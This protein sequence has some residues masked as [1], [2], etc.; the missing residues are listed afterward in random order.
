MILNF[1]YLAADAVTTLPDSVG[2]GTASGVCGVLVTA[3][4]WLSKIYLNSIELARSEYKTSHQELVMLT[5]ECI[6]AIR[7]FQATMM[8]LI[9]KLDLKDNK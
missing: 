8:E 7:E 4:I 3:I 2:L 9:N 5:R 1:I 6:T